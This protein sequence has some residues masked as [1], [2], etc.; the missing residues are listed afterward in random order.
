MCSGQQPAHKSP[1]TLQ[2][3]GCTQN[4]SIHKCP[5][6][7]GKCLLKRWLGVRHS[8]REVT[9]HVDQGLSNQDV[10]HAQQQ[11]HFASDT[12]RHVMGHHLN[13]AGHLLQARHL[14]QHLDSPP[15]SVCCATI[16]HDNVPVSL[17]HWGTSQSC[18]HHP[19]MYLKW[20]SPLQCEWVMSTGERTIMLF[21]WYDKWSQHMQGNSWQKFL[22]MYTLQSSYT[23]D[24][25][26]IL[27]INVVG[28]AVPLQ[29]IDDGWCPDTFPASRIRRAPLQLVNQVNTAI[30]VV[31]R[32]A[33]WHRDNWNTQRQDRSTWIESWAKTLCMIANFMI[34]SARCWFEAL[35]TQTNSSVLYKL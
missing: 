21:H 29:T 27:D 9:L 22:N 12:S 35:A 16:H 2:L 3:E 14:L 33:T 24:T 7:V 8:V 26:R 15:L 13:Q 1:T 34:N 25:C 10:T 30:D 31:F 4:Q 6:I 23:A 11:T 17:D 19:Q 5:V 20:F 18:R 28:S 32:I